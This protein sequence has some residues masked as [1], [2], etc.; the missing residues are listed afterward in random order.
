MIEKGS[1]N[2]DIWRL[3]SALNRIVKRSR[4]FIQASLRYEPGVIG[5]LGFSN[6]RVPSIIVPRGQTQPQ[7][8]RPIKTVAARRIPE[9][10]R[11]EIQVP[12]ERTDVSPT[13][14]RFE[15]EDPRKPEFRPILDTPSSGT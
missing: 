3:K 6:L 12:D 1:K 10:P 15:R 7:K 2:P 4:Y 14:G 11:A 13:R 5:Y 8:N 9:I